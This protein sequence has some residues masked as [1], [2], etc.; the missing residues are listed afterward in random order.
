MLA[1]R[2]PRQVGLTVCHMSGLIAS[3]LSAG[4]VLAG[5]GKLWCESE[6]TFLVSAV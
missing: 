6:L 2:T 1:A 5:G 3:R 4:P